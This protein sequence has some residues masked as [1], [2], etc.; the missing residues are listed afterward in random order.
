MYWCKT[1]QRTAQITNE[2]HKSLIN[3]LRRIVA[4]R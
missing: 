3:V 4:I 1:W 2:L